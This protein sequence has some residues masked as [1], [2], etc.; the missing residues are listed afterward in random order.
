MD[1]SELTAYAKERYGIEE[2]RK[3]P[4]SFP[5]FSVLVDPATR[6]WA[7]LLMRQW[8]G[9]RGEEIQRCDLKCGQQALLKPH[10]NFLTRPLRMKGPKWLGVRV[11]ERTDAQTVLRLFD[12]ALAHEEHRG[13]EIV[14]D[15]IQ[16]PAGKS[17]ASAPQ[18]AASL[19]TSAQPLFEAPEDPVPEKILEMRRLYEPGDGTLLQK[20]ENFRRQGAFMAD[21]VDDLPYTGGFHHYFPTY[22]DLNIP[23]LRGYF[24]WRA[25][26]REGHFLPIATSLAYIYLYELLCGIGVDSPEDALRKME[27]FEAGFLGADLGNA[28]MRRNL[29]RWMFEFCVLHGLPAE[30]ARAHLAPESLERDRALATLRSPASRT[31]EEVFFALATFAG[32]KLPQS[33]VLKKDAERGRHLFASVWR[34]A[35]QTCSQNGKGLFEVC[36]G[37]RRSYTWRPLSNAI[38][39]EES[40]PQEGFSY[41]LNECRSFRYGA[42]SWLELRYEPLFFD[43]DAFQGFVHETDRILRKRLKTGHYL[44]EKPEEAWAR[45]CIEAALAA[46]RR[47]RNQAARQKV[48]ID[49]SGLEQIRTEASA[50]RDSL[51]TESE[52]GDDFTNIKAYTSSQEQAVEPNLPQTDE[53]D[54]PPAFESAESSRVP[55]GLDEV[56]ARI[57]QALL[58]GEPVGGLIRVHHLMPSVVADTVNEALFDEVGDNVLECEGDAL[59]LVEDYRED[60][61]ELLEEA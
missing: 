56:H 60:I 49:F 61:A 51:L 17:P 54:V 26:L 41:E 47:T 57:L 40:A 46:E 30:N 50:T 45:P 38:H 25:A 27:E 35:V 18:P 10:P 37:Q 8:D 53:R 22:H 14:L 36:F 34:H 55:E 9:E 31:D 21:Y 52:L 16:A 24:T 5:G 48:R 1:L 3:W 42:G 7:A 44:H 58:R 12:Q 19:P 11:D 13:Y 29:R 33:A 39:W 43:K 2:E 20:N 23:Q 4:S 32:K 28:G 15:G 6:T 59:A